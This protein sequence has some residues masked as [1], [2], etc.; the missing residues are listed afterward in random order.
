MRK[1]ILPCVLAVTSLATA[2][3][4][5]LLTKPIDIDKK[6]QVQQA[7]AT[8][9]PGSDLSRIKVRFTVKNVSGRSLKMGT[10]EKKSQDEPWFGFSVGFAEKK[11]PLM[12]GTSLGPI[13]MKD[14]APGEVFVVEPSMG[15]PVPATYTWVQL[16]YN[17]YFGSKKGRTISGRIPLK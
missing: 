8:L 4:I 3:P 6:F 1:W 11:K 9:T 12:D 2:K 5:P 17:P 10:F 16:T 13:R 15:V 14:I 7:E